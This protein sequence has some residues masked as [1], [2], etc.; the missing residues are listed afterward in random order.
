MYEIQGFTGIV[1]SIILILLY[2]W[3]GKM[4][5]YA[6]N[7]YSLYTKYYKNGVNCD[8]CMNNYIDTKNNNSYNYIC[9]FKRNLL[10]K[11][12]CLC[13]KNLYHNRLQLLWW[14]IVCVLEECYDV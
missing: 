10:W 1:Y 3:N 9:Y 14:N 8:K 5:K 12:K 6:I 2:I 7:I 4:H 11:Y 13:K